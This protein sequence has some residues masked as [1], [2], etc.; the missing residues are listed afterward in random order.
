MSRAWKVVFNDEAVEFLLSCRAP[1]RRTLLGF[2]DKLR[3]N[4]HLAGDFAE[5][6]DTGRPLQV[7]LH[8]QFLITFWADHA[9][10]EVRIV[11]IEPAD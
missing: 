10:K 5:T 4:P 6:D 1:A 9:V 8:R 7:K 11:E 3:N 2:L